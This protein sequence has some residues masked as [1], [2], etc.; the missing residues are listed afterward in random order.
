ML[1]DRPLLVSFKPI[2]V[3]VIRHLEE[4]VA[5]ATVL[6]Q[7][8]LLI[9]PVEGQRFRISARLNIPVNEGGKCSSC[10]IADLIGGIFLPGRVSKKTDFWA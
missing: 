4:R 9:E 5:E 8:L 3:L 10:P 2:Q 7:I 1:R 6:K